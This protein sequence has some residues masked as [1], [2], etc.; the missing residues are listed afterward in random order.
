MATPS[1]SDRS[2][3][4]KALDG[5][6]IALIQETP[7]VWNSVGCWNDLSS[8]RQEAMTLLISAGLMELL[9]RIVVSMD[10]SADEL[11]LELR[12]SG[13]FSRG[14][15]RLVFDQRPQ[16]WRGPNGMSLG[17]QHLKT[18]WSQVR[19]TP[20]GNDARTMLTDTKLHDVLDYVCRRGQHVRRNPVKPE[21]SIITKRI[22]TRRLGV[23]INQS[24]MG[25]GQIIPVSGPRLSTT[26]SPNV[27]EDTEPDP[28]LS[29]AD[30]ANHYHL[31][32][33]PLRKTLD[34]WR[35]KNADGWS[36]VT[37]RKPREPR[38]LYRVS[39]V[40]SV[41][42]KLQRQTSGETSG[43]RPAR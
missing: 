23:A 26:P 31:A 16:S 21:I 12:V 29:A 3:P 25:R 19:L 1:E 11:F 2:V 18:E 13:D 43:E 32:P 10:G 4:P 27:S 42:E 8:S 37:D 7:L 22:D 9:L 40:R 34:R 30:L 15:E 17:K 33:E 14:I 35:A 38:Y 24:V 20:Q 5:E 28:M 6:I 41:I 39:A 36:E